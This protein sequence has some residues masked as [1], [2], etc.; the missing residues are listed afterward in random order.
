[1]DEARNKQKWLDFIEQEKLGGIQV[2]ASG[3]SKITKDYKINGF[4]VLS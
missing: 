2:F 1:M 3:W 4:R